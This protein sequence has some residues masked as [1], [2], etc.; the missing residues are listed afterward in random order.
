MK[1]N[2]VHV[3][4]WLLCYQNGHT[5]EKR[6]PKCYK[7]SCLDSRLSPF[8]EYQLQFANL[9]IYLSRVQRL[10]V[11]H[12]LGSIPTSLACPVVVLSCFAC[13][14]FRTIPRTFEAAKTRGGLNVI[15]VL[16]MKTG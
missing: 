2:S 6:T 13:L 12:K 3:V 9:L 4:F 16:S 5:N 8:S 11:F 7:F 1:L 15:K 10:N 14:V